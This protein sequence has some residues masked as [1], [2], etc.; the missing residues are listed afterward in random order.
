N[1]KAVPKAMIGVTVLMDLSAMIITWALFRWEVTA[2]L[3]AYILASRAYSYRGIRLKQYA[4]IGFLIVAFFQ[5]PV[6]YLLT[7]LALATSQLLIFEKT[8][9]ILCAIAFL[10]IGAGYPISQIYQHEQDKSDN[11]NTISMLLGIKGTFYFSLWMFALLNVLFC[12]Y[13]VIVVGD[14]S[15]EILLLLI[16]APVSYFFLKWMNM[17]MKDPK[18]ANFQ[19]TMKMNLIGAACNNLFFLL[20]ILK[21]NLFD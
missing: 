18:Q 9:F 5:G 3:L 8:D 12:Y 19:N 4:I 21:N 14:I 10:L 15:T 17:T 6:I 1:P 13:F 16:T 11:V 2:L 7:K 20:L